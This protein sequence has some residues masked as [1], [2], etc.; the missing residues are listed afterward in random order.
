MKG[1]YLRP[2]WVTHASASHLSL[3]YATTTARTT[4]RGRISRIFTTTTQLVQQNPQLLH[5]TFPL[6]LRRA[7]ARQSTPL[8]S[9]LRFQRA[10]MSSVTEPWPAH[11]VRETFLEY[12]KHRGHTFGMVILYYFLA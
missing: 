3:P 7:P 1:R 4:N 9:Y 2:G 6:S 10:S 12:F 5:T 8:R 11:K